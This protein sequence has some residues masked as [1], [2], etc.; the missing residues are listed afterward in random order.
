MELMCEKVIASGGQPLSPGDALKRIFEA[1][2]SGL[3]LPGSPGLLDPCEKDPMDAATPLTA[4]E[5]EDITASAQ[6]LF[7]N[8]YITLSP[9]TLRGTDSVNSCIL[10]FIYIFPIVVVEN[11]SYLKHIYYKN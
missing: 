3:L 1:L 10:Y 7:L 8:C 9:D 2:A 4:Q 11:L 5:R 6:V